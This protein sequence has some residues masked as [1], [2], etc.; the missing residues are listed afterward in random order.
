[1][2]ALVL[3]AG[4]GTRMQHVGGG[5]PKP[6]LPVG[7]QPVI[8]YL[9]DQLAALD[10]LDE[11]LVV[12]NDLHYE[13]FAQ[14]SS[15]ACCT[16]I[17]L[18]NDGTRCNEERRG[19]VGDL[20]FAIESAALDDDLLVAGGDNI[21][22]FQIA[23]LVTFFREKGADVIAVLHESRPERLV[24]SST[25]RLDEVGRVT[26]FAEKAPT[27]LSDLICPPLYIF[28]RETLPRVQE[29]LTTGGSS[30]A[31]GHFI[32]WLHR[33]TTVYGFLAPE[34][35]FDIGSPESYREACE[36]LGD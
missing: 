25:L 9:F 20:Q 22:R 5:L 29:Y 15:C 7:G 30:D 21:F 11:A 18:L 32:E 12:T 6:L 8:D 10:G 24:R 19:A 14:W 31:P 16:G 36:L 4:Y 27:P 26:A 33:E 28:R 1:M 35:R 17:R 23:S 34:G 13:Q 2:K 3:A